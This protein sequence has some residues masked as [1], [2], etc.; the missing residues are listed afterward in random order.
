MQE[1]EGK[2]KGGEGEKLQIESFSAH[3]I[4]ISH[5][6]LMNVSSLLNTYKLPVAV[7]RLWIKYVFLFAMI[8]QN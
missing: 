4:I 5:A 3:Q 6:S 7:I 2:K 8:T 1:G